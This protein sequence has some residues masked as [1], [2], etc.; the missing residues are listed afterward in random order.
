MVIFLE[1]KIMKKYLILI[2]AAFLCV[3]AIHAQSDSD[4]RFALVIGNQSYKESPLSNPIADAK[5]IAEKLRLSGFDVTCKLDLTQAEMSE[6]VGAY[7]SKIEE[8]GGNTISFFYYSGHGV[9]I[10]GKNY[11]VPVDD[12]KITTESM[13]KAKCY[14]VDSVIDLIPSKTQVIVLDACRNNPFKSSKA[15]FTKGLTQIET[16]KKVTNFLT[17]FSTQA[18]QTADDGSGRNSLFTE[19]LA[20]RMEEMN[21]QILTVFNET[22]DD[23]KTKTSGKQTPLVS[24][25]SVKFE[26]M[27]SKIAMARIK[28]LQAGVKAL[29]SSPDQKGSKEFATEKKLI[30]EDIKIMQE[31]KAASEK[32]AKA[33]AEQKKKE[34]ELLSKNKK[35]MERLRKESEKQKKALQEQKA[36]QKSAQTFIGEIEENKQR[37]Q[38]IR[39]DAADKIYAADKQTQSEADSKIKDVN[40]TPLKSTEKD[41]KGNIT[42][43]AKKSRNASIKKI[44][45]DADI[46]KQKNYERYYDAIKEEETSRLELLQADLK[47]LE[48]ASYTASSIAS[49]S[50]QSVIYKVRD[51][52]GAKNKWTVDITMSL[53]G[54]TCG[55]SADITY[56]SLC[57]NV[58]GKKYKAPEKMTQDEF[59]QYDKDINVYQPLL[60]GDNAPLLIEVEYKVSQKGGN[61]EYKF[62]TSKVQIKYLSGDEPVITSKSFSDSD[63]FI[64]EHQTEM[65]T[66]DSIL[67]EYE[68]ADAKAKKLREKERKQLQAAANSKNS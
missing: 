44:Q 3:S 64:W 67:K 22:A 66:V 13:A 12:E 17:L 21:T 15:T 41:A 20:F 40:D 4:K 62:S 28:E 6:A 31:K 24:G 52:D 59:D 10:S 55:V 23:V 39:A 46:E 42:S 50:M 68:K 19:C 5:L 18:G 43:L 27:N 26:L 60:Q 29:E 49:S 36:L 7:A 38:K 45:D 56:E 54:K 11:M 51:Y 33:K 25:T 1:K 48:S 61:S 53:F 35:E 8:A 58:I 32:D 65:K 30:E 9:Q 63:S 37:I 57:K 14:S 47:T 2:A 16:P 34:D